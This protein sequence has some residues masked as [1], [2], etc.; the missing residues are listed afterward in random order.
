MS[1]ESG[2]RFLVVIGVNQKVYSAHTQF[3]NPEFGK[4]S[5]L[6]FTSVGRPQ[7]LLDVIQGVDIIFQPKIFPA[8]ERNGHVAIPQQKVVE[9]PQAEFIS[10]C[11]V[12]V[13]KKFVNLELANLIRDGLS[14]RGCEQSGISM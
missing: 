11:T 4:I 2:I 6:G 10:G 8:L 7:P 5:N 12:C 14:S 1:T 13:G 3:V 9:R